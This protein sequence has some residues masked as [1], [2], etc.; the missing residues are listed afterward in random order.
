MLIKNSVVR[1]LSLVYVS[2]SGNV[3][4]VVTVFMSYLLTGE[5]FTGMDCFL[6]MVCLSGCTFITIGFNDQHF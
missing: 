5:R 2:L 6:L 3:T 4:P 1:H